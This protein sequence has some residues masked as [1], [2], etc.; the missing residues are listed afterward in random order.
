MTDWPTL[1]ARWQARWWD[2]GIQK[3]NR[4]ETK[5][6]FFLHFA[7]PGISGY[8]HVGHMRGFTYTDVLARSKRMAG[9]DVLFPA[10]FHASGIPAVAFAAD[11]ARGEKTQYLRD[12]GYTGAIEDL[13]DPQAVIDYFAHVYQYDYWKKFGFLIDERRDCTTVDPGY[14]RFIEWQFRRLEELGYLVTKPHYAPFCPSMGPV[15][16]DKSETDLKQ[17]GSAEVQEFIALRFQAQHPELGAIVLPCSTLRPETLYGVTNL[18]VNPTLTYHVV[19]VWKDGAVEDSDPSELWVVSEPAV[20][21]VEWQM[22]RAEATGQTVAGMD[23]LDLVATAP[24]TGAQVPTVAGSFVDAH[25][26]TGVVMSVPAHAPFDWAAYNDAGLLERLGEPPQIVTI[27]GY[28]DLPARQACLKF[29]IKSQTDAALEEATQ[30]VY[31]DEFTKGVLNERCG[32]HEGQRIRAVKDTI[33]QEALEADHG[34]SLRQFNETVISRA[35]EE[36]QIRR[37]PNQVFIHYADEAW[38][39]K[40]KEHA[41]TMTIVPQRYADDIDNV[42]DW[43]GD[44]ACVRRGSWLGTKYPFDPEWIIEPIADSTF[45]AW[46]Y[47][48]SLYVNDGRL[49]VDDLTDSFFDYVVNGRG[50]AQAPI[51]EDVRKD[52][53]HYGPVDI[54]LGG[55]EHQT[56]HFPVYIMNNVALLDD[57]AMR[58]QGLYVNWW[59][60]QKAGEKISKSKGGAEPIPGAIERFGVD[61]MRLYYCHV[62]SPHADIEWDQELVGTYRDQLDRILR[63]VS[64]WLESESGDGSMDGWLGARM[65]QHIQAARDAYDAM[66]L[67]SVTKEAHYEAFETLRTAVARGV[68]R[69]ALLAALGELALLMCPVT[70]HLAEELAQMARTAGWVPVDDHAEWICSTAALPERR[71]VDQSLLAAETYVQGVLEDIR[72]IAK[73]AGESSTGTMALYT[74]P[75]W[76]TDVLRMALRHAEGGGKFPMGA[77]MGEVMA[78][79]DMRSLGKAVQKFTGK[80]PGEIPRLTDAQR[81]TVQDLDEFE[82]LVAAKGMLAESLGLQEVQVYRADDASAPVHAKQDLAGPLKPGIVWG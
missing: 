16:V 27:E 63:N 72:T 73:L 39:A 15:A 47:L 37:V 3:A 55:K 9:Y 22:E 71:E 59:V 35:G 45:Y 21:K 51:W 75:A 76:K 2:A 40:A 14:Q 62:G 41:A 66:D 49:A 42:M 68:S 48:V 54:N 65:A 28:D 70:P 25:V 61:P 38:T 30:E 43:F 32:I 18:W 46:Y 57:P 34:R 31:Q 44:R 12:N 81:F 1:E 69:D 24:M 52:V 36:V 33:R 78:N 13:E 26:A 7:Y 80:L 77:F 4:D 56:V 82:L 19:R 60:T 50:N 64:R 74:S 53:L 10:G 17:G 79:P 5:P 6:S 23:L 11:V 67:R 8:L 20:R 58:P 29:G